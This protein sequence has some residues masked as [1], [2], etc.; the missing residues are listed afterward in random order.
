MS[1]PR[2]AWI[3][4]LRSSLCCATVIP[5]RTAW[6]ISQ[7]YSRCHVTIIR[8]RETTETKSAVRTPV[9]KYQPNLL[10]KILRNGIFG[11]HNTQHI[12]GREGGARRRGEERKGRKRD[13][14]RDPPSLR[15]RKEGQRGETSL[16]C[17]GTVWYL[18]KVY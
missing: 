2:T 1:V 16:H 14:G 13:R 9:T 4:S 6:I 3:I 7:I 10:C 15:G 12:R 5:C 17:I 18:S 11:E 8:C